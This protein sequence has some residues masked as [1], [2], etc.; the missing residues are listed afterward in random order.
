MLSRNIDTEL[1]DFFIFLHKRKRFI[2]L[3]MGI[4]LIIGLI[5][6]ITKWDQWVISVTLYPTSAQSISMI[7]Y[8]RD[9]T[10]IIKPLSSIE[11]FAIYSNI[12]LSESFQKKFINAHPEEKIFLEI[13]QYGPT[14]T[15][16]KLTAASLNSINT[17]LN[18][19]LSASKKA[20]LDKINQMSNKI[21]EIVEHRTIKDLE[22]KKDLQKYQA[23]A[24][25]LRTELSTMP[26]RDVKINEVKLFEIGN[27]VVPKKLVDRFQQLKILVIFSIFGFLTSIMILLLIFLY[28][29]NELELK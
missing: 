27:A 25:K 8:G 20:A 6:C 22:N 28:R 17:L 26:H 10:S 23:L 15:Y 9:D 21:I 16:V 11:V 18:E 29:Q 14:Q 7:N 13:E 2:W 5:K 24:D 12:A 19:Y 3:I 4:F 1:K